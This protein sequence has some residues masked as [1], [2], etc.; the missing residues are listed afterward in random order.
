MSND[1]CTLTSLVE[2]RLSELFRHLKY[3][4]FI[5]YIYWYKNL[6]KIKKLEVPENNFFYLKQVMFELV[7]IIEVLLYSFP[8]VIFINSLKMLLGNVRFEEKLVC[9]PFF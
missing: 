5:F 1:N 4:F 9:L 2:L 7:W 3:K 8:N 6:V